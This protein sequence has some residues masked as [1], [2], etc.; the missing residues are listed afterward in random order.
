[1]KIDRNVYPKGWNLAR[2]QRVIDYYE[3]HSIVER[4]LGSGLLKR[5]VERYIAL[6]AIGVVSALRTSSLTA[7]RACDDLF[8]L[9]GY[10]ALTKRRMS[11]AA[12]EIMKRGMELVDVAE[13]A[14]HKLEENYHA[15]EELAKEILARMR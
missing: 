9:D 5:D 14:P 11:K 12:K 15:I 6:L 10:G 4:L 1:M 7:V 13:L 3:R 8:N 2:V